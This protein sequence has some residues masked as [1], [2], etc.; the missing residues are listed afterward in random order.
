MSYNSI[1]AMKFIKEN[2]N[3]V[4]LISLSL[5]LPLVSLA[6]GGNSG[7][8]PGKICN[9]ISGSTTIQGFI[10]TLLEGVLRIGIPIV[11][12]AVIYSGFL[13]VKARGNAKELETAKSSLVYTL[14]GAAILLGSWAIAKLIADT[15]LAL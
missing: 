2:L 9:P 7:C 15:V 5:T 11:A 12:L 1:Q 8:E 14:I 6:D 10:R 4:F 3:R 13:F